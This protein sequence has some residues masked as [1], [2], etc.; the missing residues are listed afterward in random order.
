MYIKLR[1]SVWTL[2]DVLNRFKKLHPQIL[3]P[4]SP[5]FLSRPPLAVV[6]PPPP[7]ANPSRSSARFPRPQPCHQGCAATASPAPCWCA[8]VR[9]CAATV[10]PTPAPV[11]SRSAPSS[12]R[13]VAMLVLVTL[14]GEILPLSRCF[15]CLS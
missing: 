5:L 2:T 8:R 15:F 14:V 10:R 6:A 4:F 12:A 7:H 1:T 13:D 11:S 3:F 9:R